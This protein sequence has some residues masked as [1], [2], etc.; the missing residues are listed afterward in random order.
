[1]M[2][3]PQKCIKTLATEHDRKLQLVDE[4]YDELDNIYDVDCI[5]LDKLVCES[6]RACLNNAH[7]YEYALQQYINKQ[8]WM[9]SETLREAVQGWYIRCHCLR[10]RSD[11]PVESTISLLRRFGTKYVTVPQVRYLLLKEVSLPDEI[12][13]RYYTDISKPVPYPASV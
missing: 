7:S 10:I 9:N 4:I 6:V 1:M 13:H 2:P 8:C 11:T 3:V 12:K 5:S